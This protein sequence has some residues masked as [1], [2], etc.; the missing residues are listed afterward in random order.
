MYHRARPMRFGSRGSSE[1]QTEK[2]WEGALQELGKGLSEPEKN[3]E[4]CKLPKCDGN[5]ADITEDTSAPKREKLKEMFE[6]ITE[7]VVRTSIYFLVN[8][9]DSEQLYF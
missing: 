4:P 1:A 2:A 9:R 3:T 7:K 6:C 5:Q 8:F